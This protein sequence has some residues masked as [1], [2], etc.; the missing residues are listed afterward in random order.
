MLF[1]YDFQTYTVMKTSKKKPLTYSRSFTSDVPY[2]LYFLALY[3]SADCPRSCLQ[4]IVQV[5]CVKATDQRQ[6]IWEMYHWQWEKII[7]SEPKVFQIVSGGFTVKDMRKH[8]TEL[9]HRVPDSAINATLNIYFS[10]WCTFTISRTQNEDERCLVSHKYN[11]CDLNFALILTHSVESNQPVLSSCVN[12]AKISYLENEICYFIPNEEGSVYI[13]WNEAQLLCRKYK[14]ILAM[15]HER[16]ALERAKSIA[17]MTSLESHHS[18]LFLGIK[19]K[20]IYN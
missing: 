14:G 3:S 17:S 2:S 6:P 16:S 15:F 1:S 20:V 5:K 10:S 8:S 9:Q 12:N 18:L 19:Y 7:T 11:H 13:S 4:D